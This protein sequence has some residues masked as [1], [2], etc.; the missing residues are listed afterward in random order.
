M[1]N[2]PSP[3]S[4]SPSEKSFISRLSMEI[5]GA[6]P[7]AESIAMCSDTGQSGESMVASVS[8]SIIV[9]LGGGGTHRTRLV[10]AHSC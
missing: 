7:E 8:S 6:S 5:S 1:S 10:G 3:S 9:H 2:S 4:A